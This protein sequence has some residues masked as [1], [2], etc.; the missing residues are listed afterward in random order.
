MDRIIICTIT[1]LA[2]ITT[3]FI[4]TLCSGHSSPHRPRSPRVAVHTSG[5]P[6]SGSVYEKKA[7]EHHHYVPRRPVPG[8]QGA[9]E[10]ILTHDK[11]LLHDK[12]HLKEDLGDWVFADGKELTPEEMEFHYFKMHDFDNNSMLDG[13]EI[14]Q[15]IS[16]ILPVTDVDESVDL[17][18]K[19]ME[20]SAGEKVASPSLTGGIPVENPKSRVEAEIKRAELLQQRQEDFDYYIDL[21]DK[22]LEE[23][24]LNKDGYLSYFEY[25]AGRRRD[26]RE[27]KAK[28]QA[29]V[30]SAHTKLTK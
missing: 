14:L 10:P 19:N 26:E 15:A 17:S 16:H 4:S 23:D 21:I 25:V 11:Q 13:L 1:T 2:I 22:V 30:H 8:S 5:S 7:E 24:D 20:G 12:E 27:E 3:P 18:E 28:A 9:T 29:A 6:G